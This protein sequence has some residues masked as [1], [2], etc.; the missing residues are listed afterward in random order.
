M[1]DS[2]ALRGE[3]V[4]LRGPTG[5]ARGAFLEDLEAEVRGHPALHRPFL[6]RFAEGRLGTEGY[7]LDWTYPY[8]SW[9][10]CET[11]RAYGV[12]PTAAA[13]STSL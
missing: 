4:N 5:S 11:S 9:L 12:G 6:R 3:L 13:C 10:E 2:Q 7:P 1:E 8:A